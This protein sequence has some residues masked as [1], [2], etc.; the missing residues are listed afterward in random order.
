MSVHASRYD[1]AGTG[2][3]R[4]RARRAAGWA[5]A[6]WL[7]AAALLG[8]PAAGQAPTTLPTQPVKPLRRETEDLTEAKLGARVKEVSD[9][10]EMDA[11]LRQAL[12][13]LYNR[14]L[15]Q[16]RQAAGFRKDLAGSEQVM[17]DAPQRIKQLEAAASQPTSKPVVK[18]PTTMPLK[19]MESHLKQYE[20]NVT[21]LQQQ[22]EKLEAELK[23][24]ADER[25]KAPE[26]AAAIKD[27]LAEVDAKVKALDKSKDPP[28]VQEAQ[29]T[30]LLAR[31]M[32]LEAE[33]QAQEK[34]LAAHETWRT[35]M[36]A[37]QA[38][39]ARKISQ[40]QA[41]VAAWQPEVTRRR[42][43]EAR[44]QL[45]AAKKA[46]RMARWQHEVVQQLARENTALAEFRAGPTGLNERR[47]RIDEALATATASLEA[48]EA[49]FKKVQSMVEEVGETDAVGRLLREQR[50]ALPDAREFRRGSAAR[51]E[52]ISRVR[53]KLFELNEMDAALSDVEKRAQARMD[54][55]DPPIPPDERETV[56]G[57]V[58]QA[59]QDR[60]KLL[61]SLVADYEKHFDVLV[62]LG[63]L[64]KRLVQRAAEF[65]DYIDERVFWI[66]ST[67]PVGLADARD[68]LDS[69]LWLGAAGAWWQVAKAFA[70][71]AARAA[72][73]YV[74]AAVILGGLLLARRK[75]A[76]EVAEVGDDPARPGAT[77]FGKTL[78]A[79]LLTAL[80]AAVF[81]A[82][83]WFAGWRLVTAESLA[84]KPI[85]FV[86]AAGHGLVI[87][88]AFWFPAAILREICRGR[89]LGAGHFG[90]PVEAVRRVRRS[91]AAVLF[92][93]LPLVF[94]VGMVESQAAAAHKGSL[95]RAALVIGL[96]VLAGYVARLLRPGG[97]L[98]AQ[99]VA[100]RAGSWVHRLRYLWY[101]LAVLTPPALAAAALA[102]YQYTAVQLSW[103][104]LAQV[105]AI[106]ALI[107][108]HALLIRLAGAARARGAAGAG[109]PAAKE[110]A[111]SP[112][113]PEAETF[114]LTR[115]LMVALVLLSVWLVWADV[116]PALSKLRQVECWSVRVN[117]ESQ[118][119]T[120]ADLCLAAVV[121]AL[122]VAAGKGISGILQITVFERLNVETGSR[123]AAN[124]LMRYLI[125]VVG[126]VIA[127]RVIGL[128]WSHVQWLVAM[129]LFG[130]SFGLQEIVANFVSGLII[131]FERPIRVGDV[132]T[133]SGT[134]GRVARIRIRATTIVDLDRKEL[135]VPNKEFVT[136]QLVNW[137]LSDNVIRQIIP[138][139]IAYGSDTRRAREV[140]LSAARDNARVLA[141]PP[142][143]V[144]F[145][146]FGSSSLDF[147]LRV[148]V[149]GYSDFHPAR[150]ELHLAIDSAFRDSGIEIAFPQQDL[151]LRSLPPGLVMPGRAR[152]DAP[153]AADGGAPPAGPY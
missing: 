149:Q 57:S 44:R 81:P 114:V 115:H 48:L 2:R 15:Q 152:A 135:I 5:P 76:A 153:G 19:E 122:T 111:P 83:A 89:G 70:G 1:T 8:G 26:R 3:L 66:R 61:D 36:R 145:M 58:R 64:E 123:Y 59:L 126:V 77:G 69:L 85:A 147:E 91:L 105:W 130:V 56:L 82:A 127:C 90:W 119:I 139:G 134:T 13:D 79:L 51:A 94:V 27:G 31:R 53:T 29:R 6:C 108:L 103:R 110:Q 125:S 96:L 45:E 22:A 140:L 99:T 84:A 131:L 39:L 120:L 75:A 37:E 18:L 98:V 42:D 35:W 32:S 21:T 74:L 112:A 137:T 87:T 24:R 121:L 151:H 95:G 113:A 30:E 50:A 63:A 132:V 141:E 118:A 100:A 78:W 88:A 73:P 146:G 97:A 129:M 150:S 107:V 133:V 106:V 92:V 60:K 10:K 20:L 117:G 72:M 93:L 41:V 23:G 101:P 128:R 25:A 49:S 124:T 11:P 148:F 46:E 4:A 33:L 7:L 9:A 14:A 54:A 104:L 52:E 65:A 71:D 28:A 43:E 136:G 16:V 47:R 34:A 86:R 40:V 62:Q 80:C 55:A 142:P 144:L 67:R 12:L 68:C 109:E 138:V 102:G 17:R 38:E 116:L 143:E